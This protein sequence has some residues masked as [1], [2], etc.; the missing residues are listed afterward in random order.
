MRIIFHTINQLLQQEH[1]TFFPDLRRKFMQFLESKNLQY[2]VEDDKYKKH[3]EEAK[4]FAGILTYEDHRRTYWALD[5]L[6]PKSVGTTIE[7]VAYLYLLR[8]SGGYVVPLLL[9][10]RLLGIRDHLLAPDYLLVVGRKVYGI[11]VE[12]LGDTG[13]VRQSNE[14]V[15]ETGIPVLT[16]SV[17]NTIPLRCCVCKRWILFCDAVI[18]KFCDI[19]QPLGS[20]RIHCEGCNEEIY[21]GRLRPGDN[22]Y[23]YHLRCV[24][25]NDY[26][27]NILVD[28]EQRQKRLI[29]YFPHLQGLERLVQPTQ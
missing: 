28:P 3:Y 12:Q 13:K 19:S 25:N 26:V 1:V 2:Y 20:D 6:L 24:Q 17:P 27:Q 22:E 7:L 9:Q 8:N 5:H 23:H 14:F 10:Q 29:A 4:K 16:A 11:E 21:H 15:S 18:E